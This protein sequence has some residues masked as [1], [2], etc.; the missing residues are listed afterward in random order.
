MSVAPS[1]PNQFSIYLFIQTI[2]GW[3]VFCFVGCRDPF[4]GSN[5]VAAFLQTSSP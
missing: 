4:M 2:L 5:L 3:H 1:N